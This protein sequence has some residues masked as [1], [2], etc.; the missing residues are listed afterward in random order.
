MI[1]AALNCDPE[2]KNAQIHCSETDLTC[3][4]T[5]NYNYY[6]QSFV[7]S[8]AG[9]LRLVIDLASH[10]FLLISA[11]WRVVKNDMTKI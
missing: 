7:C 9:K 5:T 6:D 10:G 2:W 1:D 4:Q 3:S 11:A 8:F